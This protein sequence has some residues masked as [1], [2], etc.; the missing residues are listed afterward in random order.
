MNACARL[1][2]R[3]EPLSWKESSG[4]IYSVIAHVDVQL[5]EGQPL[6]KYSTVCSQ[7]LIGARTC[8]TAGGST[9]NASVVRSGKVVIR[10]VLSTSES[11][12]TDL[13]ALCGNDARRLTYVFRGLDV[14]EQRIAGHRSVTDS[15]KGEVAGNHMWRNPARGKHLPEGQLLYTSSPSQPQGSGYVTYHSI[16]CCLYRVICR[17]SVLVTQ[18]TATF[19]SSI[20]GSVSSCRDDSKILSHGFALSKEWQILGPFQIGT[21]ELYGGF[22]ALEYNTSTSFRSSLAFNG[23]VSWSEAHAK[24]DN[25]V[26]RAEA[27]F[28]VSFPDIDWGFLQRVYGWTS[29]QWQGWARGHILIRSNETQILTFNA[30]QVLE[31]WINN[32]HYFGGDFYGFER[33]AVTLRLEPGVHRLDVRLIRD[34]RAMGG[35]GTPTLDVDL[36]LDSST[37]DLH[38]LRTHR[39]PSANVLIADL[40]G[41]EAGSFNSPYASVAVR[42]DALE[43]AYVLGVKGDH[44]KSEAQL[45]SQE[46][47]KLVPGQSRPLPFRI[48]CIS[49]DSCSELMTINV[50]Y[51]L[52][53]SDKEEK[54]ISI[55]AWPQKRGVYEP[56]KITYMHPGGIVSYAILRPPS[57][58]AECSSAEE[59]HLPIL[60]QLHGAGVDV[61][62]DVVRHTLDPFPDLCAWVLF[63]SGVTDWSGDDWHQW[64]LAD[65]EAAVAAIPDWIERNQWTGPGVDVDRWLVGGHSNGGQGTWYLATHRPDKV[66]AAASLSGYSSIQNYV[67]YTFWHSTD[68]GRMAIVHSVLNSYRHELLLENVADMPVF[69]QHGSADD[70]VP[71]YHSRLMALQSQEAGV[72]SSFEEMAGRPHYWDGVMTT[73]SLAAFYEQNLNRPASD[74]LPHDLAGFSVVSANFGDMGPRKGI[75]ILELITPGQLGRIDVSFHPLVAGGCILRTSNV[76]SF[77]VPLLFSEC[78][79]SGVDG[80]LVTAL[81]S[82]LPYTDWTLENGNW[83]S[84]GW[85]IPLDGYFPP[86]PP[87]MAANQLG[88]LDA[89]LRTR[90]IPSIVVHSKAARDVALQISRNLYQYYAAD[91]VI[92]E[93]YEAAIN[94]WGNNL[95]SVAIGADLPAGIEA[96]FHAIKVS[97]DHINIVDLDHRQHYYESTHGLAAIFLRPAQGRRLEL[98]VW[99]VDKENLEVAARMVPLMTG[100]GQPDFVIAD[101]SILLKG[102]GGTLALGFLDSYWNVSRNSYFT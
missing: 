34:V 14:Q 88:P 73:D 49:P 90:G 95:I 25:S 50:T 15:R 16:Y 68:P 37:C 44:D 70:N 86:M 29:L 35:V 75:E 99:G 48:A 87:R 97:S 24:V 61:D 60:I 11:Q 84:Q 59:K 46:P 66:I 21:R 80:Q 74:T 102:L 13:F 67:P 54:T 23:T 5:R 27:K 78:K 33:A 20:V 22:R 9:T 83:A 1:S 57:N 10:A 4:R 39:K 47:I 77:R 93:D 56:Q 69:L 76:L 63:P 28:S 12:F 85:S 41:G 100:S 26:T 18:Y 32:K 19:Q 31:F 3:E 8:S 92:T 45:I 96:Y 65:V 52:G 98:I 2:L 58:N 53:G 42:N 91:S 51:C 79:I 101:K 64:G 81:Q 82:G 72:N 7:A 6:G 62:S 89:I 38:Q 71:S 30:K 55:L 43:D 36:A 17:K 94:Q 40:F